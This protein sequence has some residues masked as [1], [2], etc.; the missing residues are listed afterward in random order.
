MEKILFEVRALENNEGELKIK[1]IVND[2][3]YSREMLDDNGN[4]FIE[5]IDREVFQKA[6]GQSPKIELWLN[7]ENDFILDDTNK[8]L[9][10]NATEKGLEMIATL[11]NQCR[12]L[13]EKIKS[14]KL[15]FSFGFD[16]LLDEWSKDSVG[17]NL[18]NVKDLVIREISILS[19]GVTPAYYNTS[20]QTRSIR[21][22]KKL[23]DK[24][25]NEL[26]LMALEL[27]LL[28]L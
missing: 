4:T 8:S 28:N 21:V 16:C 7:H 15:G 13:Y 22:P 25:I 11:P 20:V 24:Y 18:R 2:Y 10:L 17:T 1:G 9:V 5:K 23:N 26:N 19:E 6:L 14:G 3:S 12:N 27:D